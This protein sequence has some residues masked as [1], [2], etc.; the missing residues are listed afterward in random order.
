MTGIVAIAGAVF[1]Q[2]MARHAEHRCNGRRLT[3]VVGRCGT[4]GDDR[5][6]VLPDGLRRQDRPP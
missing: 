2:D 6:G 5:V 1:E 3:R 4:L